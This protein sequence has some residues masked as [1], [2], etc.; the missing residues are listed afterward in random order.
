MTTR[1]N[2]RAALLLSVL[3]LLGGCDS[4]RPSGPATTPGTLKVHLTAPNAA[5]AA[6]LIQLDGAGMSS[7]AVSGTGLTS[8][9]R[10]ASATRTFV[11]IFGSLRSGEILRFDV[12]NTKVSSAYTATV[13]EVSDEANTLLAAS[14]YSLSVRR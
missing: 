1:F 9:V 11:A 14:A 6:I 2:E 12:P 8:Y 13:I 5:D 10:S 7:V 3:A 4:G